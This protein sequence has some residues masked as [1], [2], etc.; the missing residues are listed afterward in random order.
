MARLGGGT[1]PTT[2]GLK[3]TKFGWI[4]LE[5]P[6]NEPSTGGLELGRM[7]VTKYITLYRPKLTLG[8]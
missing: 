5:Q 8:A 1:Q 7:I 3:N 2:A 6:Y 4:Y